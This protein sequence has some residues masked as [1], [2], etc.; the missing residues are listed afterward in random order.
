MNERWTRQNVC[1]VLKMKHEMKE[2][3]GRRRYVRKEKNTNLSYFYVQFMLDG[4]RTW[5]D[6]IICKFLE[7]KVRRRKTFSAMLLTIYLFSFF[8]FLFSSKAFSLKFSIF[9]FRSFSIFYASSW[10][11]TN[12]ASGKYSSLVLRLCRKCA[13]KNEKQ[14]ENHKYKHD[15]HTHR[16]HFRFDTKKRQ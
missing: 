12:I 15:L 8:A 1:R 16:I 3:W 14:N 9:F 6:I 5:E 7:R 2:E 4:Y 10:P 11:S 13:E